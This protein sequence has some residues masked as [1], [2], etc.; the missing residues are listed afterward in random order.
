[1]G[2]VLQRGTTFIIKWGNY[3]KVVQYR[4]KMKE[5][6]KDNRFWQPIPWF[7]PDLPED[8][9]SAPSKFLKTWRSR[10]RIK[11]RIN[12]TPPTGVSA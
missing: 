8:R 4:R 11:V 1:M 9:Q 7:T 6:G 3:Y 5:K 12:Q 2:Q 10:I